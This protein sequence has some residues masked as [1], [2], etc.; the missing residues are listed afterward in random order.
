MSRTPVHIITGFL[1]AG[2][3][4]FLNHLITNRLP[5]RILVI[6]NEVGEVNIDGALV[7]DGADS[8]VELT[9]GCICCSLNDDLLEVLADLAGRRHTFDRIVIETTGIA[10]P[11]AV[12]ETFIG[13]PRVERDFEL[14]NV[15]GLA[16]ARHLDEALRDTDEA[17]RQIAFSDVLLLNKTDLAQ[18]DD[19]AVLEQTLRGINPLA[20]VYTGMHGMF[21]VD[22]V[23]TTAVMEDRGAEQ[24]T[25]AVESFHQHQRHD[26][27]S[28]ALTFDRDF[29]LNELHH[30]LVV[31]LN[32]YRHQVYRVKGIVAA[33]GSPVKV[34]VQ[35]VRN[36]LALS[37]GTP[38]QPGEVRQTKIVFIGR[39]VKRESIERIFRNCL[40]VPVPV[41]ATTSLARKQPATRKPLD[42]GNMLHQ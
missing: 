14:F 21:P 37:D 11:G 2:K 22:E 23:L 27:T 30:Q 15:I 3:T 19:L 10:D 5:E 34:V 41:S 39:G 4:T 42:L 20:K 12:A 29:D 1:G 33:A 6:E 26:I 38:W 35:S 32:V 7:V 36:L 18:P 31:L 8:V 28:F 24:Q 25:A 17:R 16:D 9:A 13:D 40:H